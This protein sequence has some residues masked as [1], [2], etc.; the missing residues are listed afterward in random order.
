MIVNSLLKAS[1]RMEI[2]RYRGGGHFLIF[3]AA[4]EGWSGGLVLVLPQ[5]CP[6]IVLHKCSKTIRGLLIKFFF[7]CCFKQTNS[8][9][10]VA[11]IKFEASRGRS[12]PNTNR[13][14]STMEPIPWLRRP[15]IHHHPHFHFL[16]WGNPVERFKSD[17]RSLPKAESP[18]PILFTD[19]ISG[20][21]PAPKSSCTKLFLS[22][23]SPIIALS[24][25]SVMLNFVQIGFI[26]L[27]RLIS[28]LDL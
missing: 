1:K 19:F 22:D 10:C 21:L 8:N 13:I 15:P 5:L 12:L 11:H 23:P 14:V 28:L 7:P 4:N 20:I 27:V 17:S 6:F 26:K 9:V 3:G 18:P 24:C 16:S 2:F 25:H